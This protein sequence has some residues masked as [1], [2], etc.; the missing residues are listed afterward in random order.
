MWTIGGG[1][2]CSGSIWGCE[3]AGLSAVRHITEQPVTVLGKPCVHDGSTEF[4]T[5]VGFLANNRR[6]W[7]EMAALRVEN[8]NIWRRRVQITEAGADM[9]GA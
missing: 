6:A 3:R 5:R 2:P 4:A 9:L 7:G 8:V 1:W